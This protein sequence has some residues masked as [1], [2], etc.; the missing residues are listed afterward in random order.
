[1]SPIGLYLLI[2]LDAIILLA[3][4]FMVP[5]FA[6]AILAL[7]TWIV[8]WIIP[9]SYATGDEYEFGNTPSDDKIKDCKA[10]CGGLRR[11]VF[12]VLLLAMLI[13]LPFRL[14]ASL[15]PSTREMAIIY[16]VPKVTNNQSVQQLPDKLL[17]LSSEWLE[18]LRPENVKESVKTVVQQPH[19]KSQ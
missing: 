2:K 17:R 3:K 13:W 1:M 7:L 6:L 18:E 16:V 19:A 8:L 15:L 11:P 9:H 10:M 5:S 14:I 4:W 12:K